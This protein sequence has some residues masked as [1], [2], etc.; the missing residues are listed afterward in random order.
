MS[1][2]NNCEEKTG[3]TSYDD[4]LDRINKY[5]DFCRK[6]WGTYMG[7]LYHPL[8]DEKGMIIGAIRISD[9]EEKYYE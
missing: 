4:H 1:Q 8:Y 7:G 3:D 5:R 9:K 6:S 2:H